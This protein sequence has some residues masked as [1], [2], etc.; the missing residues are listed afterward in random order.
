MNLIDGL[1]ILAGRVPRKEVKV[2]L[3]RRRT[4]IHLQFDLQ[5]GSIIRLG[6]IVASLLSSGQQA[7]HKISEVN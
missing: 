1:I 3:K 4:D 2:N 7:A 6:Y 5:I